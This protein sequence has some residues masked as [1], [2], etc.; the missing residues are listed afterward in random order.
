MGDEY[1]RKRCQFIG[2]SFGKAKE[3]WNVKR[4][5]KKEKR[6]IY[7]GSY[8]NEDTAA[9]ASDTLARKL[10]ANGEE[11]HKLNFPDEI[12]DVHAKPRKNSSK[13]FG[14]SYNGEKSRWEVQRHS[15]AEQKKISNGYH[16]D[17]KKA[18]YASDSLA[19]QLIANGEQGH[20]LNFPA[21]VYPIKAKSPF[22]Y[23]GVFYNAKIKKWRASRWSITKKK[24]VSNGYYK[25]EKTA[26]YASDNLARKLL[27][28][29]AQNLKLNFPGVNIEVQSKT[30]LTCIGVYY[31]EKFKRWWAQRWSKTEKKICRDRNYHKDEKAAAHASDALAMK[32]IA[33]GEQGHKL[34]F[35]DDSTE[36]HSLPHP[37]KR[38]RDFEYSDSEA[39]DNN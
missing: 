39:D 1:E 32:L 17:E 18:A 28:D 9:Q 16:R 34:N 38:K 4:W 11:G 25:D 12:N 31:N 19:R 13:F 15:K 36:A 8:K 37:S 26:A 2:L 10:I 3:I 27:A 20:K 5:S 24:P 35:P 23:I 33:N 14:V 7:N 6:K 21:E 29:G 22:K 30:N